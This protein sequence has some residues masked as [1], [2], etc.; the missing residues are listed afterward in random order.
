MFLAIFVDEFGISPG[1]S[2]ILAIF[3]DESRADG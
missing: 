2:T 3:M 1:S